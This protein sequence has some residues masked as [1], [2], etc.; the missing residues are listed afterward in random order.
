MPADE[1][2]REDYKALLAVID[3]ARHVP[4]GY[5]ETIDDA[6]HALG[7][8][9]QHNPELAYEDPM[10]QL[11][12]QDKYLLEKYTD[13]VRDYSI[14]SNEANSKPFLEWRQLMIERLNR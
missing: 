5:G 4:G 2:T 9:L 10:D 6:M 7:V 1:F 8:L 3:L 12:E 13:A 11:G 14:M